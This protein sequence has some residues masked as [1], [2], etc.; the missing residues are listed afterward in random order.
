ME[1]I[2]NGSD[3]RDQTWQQDKVDFSQVLFILDTAGIQHD[4]H[5]PADGL[6]RQVAAK[7]ASDDSIGTVSP[8]DLSPVDAEGA[9]LCFG[10][11]GNFLAQVKISIRL[12]VTSLD[13]DQRDVRV[14]RTQG[15]LVTQNGTIHVQAGSS[16]LFSSGGHCVKE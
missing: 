11:E 7:S 4:A 16:F 5:T 15:T 12:A 13:L 3:T 1:T 2:C 6:G 10:D 9:V 14:L 8:A